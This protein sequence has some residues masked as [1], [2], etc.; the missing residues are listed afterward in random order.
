MLLFLVEDN[1]GVVAVVGAIGIAGG[2]VGG[3]GGIS[4]VAEIEGDSWVGAYALA[5]DVYV[6]VAGG[7][8]TKQAQNEEGTFHD[9][10]VM[11]CWDYLQIF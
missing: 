9:Y 7:G 1:A 5:Q 2:L 10:K 8:Q 6:F 3:G 4:L 11:Y